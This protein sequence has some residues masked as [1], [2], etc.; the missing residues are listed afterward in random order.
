MINLLPPKARRKLRIE[1]IIRFFSLFIIVLAFACFVF[2]LLSV[3]TWMLQRYQIG[4]VSEDRELIA[5]IESK[6]RQ[7]ERAAVETRQ[8][9]NLFSK[10]LP[11]RQ[12][13]ELISRL[14]EIAG[15][16]IS[17]NQFVFDSKNKLDITGVA[18]TRTALT[19]FKTTVEKESTFTMVELPLS[20]LV[21]DS[22]AEFKMTLT[23]KKN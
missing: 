11:N 8:T 15:E 3:P 19:T 13:S 21:S 6:R 10:T 17:L 7:A 22:N 23:M 12:Y 4:G 16:E 14:D 2:M 9:I 5:D 20:S 1:Q 18:S